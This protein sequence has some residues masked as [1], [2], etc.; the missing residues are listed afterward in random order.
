MFESGPTIPSEMS[1]HC[2]VPISADGATVFVTRGNQGTEVYFWALGDDVWTE[3][4]ER[5]TAQRDRAVCGRVGTE[6][7]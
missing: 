7:R 5:M 4:D 2:A 6:A 3:L 1:G